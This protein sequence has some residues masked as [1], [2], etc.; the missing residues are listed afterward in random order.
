[1][2]LTSILSAAVL[3]STAVA[4]S[5][6]YVRLSKN[7]SVLVILDMQEGLIP[8]V[9]DYDPIVYKNNMLAYGSLATVWT[10]IPVVMSTSAQTGP[11]GPLPQEFLDWYPDAPL[12]QRNGEVDA[13]DNE[14]FRAAI[15]ATNKTQVILGGIV[16]DV[17]T[18]FLARSLRAEGYDVWAV[19]EASGTSTPEVRDI[20][21]DQMIKAGVNVV[22]LF[23]VLGELMRD[24]RNT[25]GALEVWPWVDKYMPAG[26]INA[27]AH[28]AAILN[29]T[30]VPGQD[31]LPH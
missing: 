1:M 20:A 8:L 4:D 5:Y 26:G 2:K 13:W 15:K 7:E 21:N 14:E 16:T 12:I 23:A 24:W 9:R 31:Q 6:P 10:E 27:R 19:I 25:P 28:R 17:C 29:G 22:S 18:A 30:I 11:N 3:A